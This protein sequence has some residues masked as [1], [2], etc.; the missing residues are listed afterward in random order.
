MTAMSDRP[1]PFRAC[2]WSMPGVT[3]SR[4]TADL[5]LRDSAPIR[6]TWRGAA[7]VPPPLVVHLGREP[8]IDE[9]AV[10]LAA[11]GA[12]DALRALEWCADHGAELGGDPRRLILAG[13]HSAAG[14][15]AAL[16]RHARDRG[17]PPIERIVLVSTSTGEAMTLQSYFAITRAVYA[18]RERLFRAW[19]QPEELSRWYSGE[20]FELDEVDEPARMVFTTDEVDLAIVTLS[21]VGDHTVMTFE[22]SAQE[23]EV[24]DVERGWASMLDALATS[25]DQGS[26][27][28]GN[29]G[30][31]RPG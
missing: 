24:E 20:P 28:G 5:H 4:P 18:S 10:V 23:A 15:V 8:R 29:A 19:T 25:V 12:G 22:G 11:S 21:V 26:Q 13:E 17:W 6:V 2:A 16:A 27:S 14:L 1:F 9:P 30:G 3:T 31:I 7:V